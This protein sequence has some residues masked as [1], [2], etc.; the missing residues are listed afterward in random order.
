MQN[1]VINQKAISITRGDIKGK[2]NPDGFQSQE[3][4][5]NFDINQV[6]AKIKEKTWLSVNEIK[7][8]LK[9]IDEKE[10]RKNQESFINIAIETIEKCKKNYIISIAEVKYEKTGENFDDEHFIQEERQSYHENLMESEKSLFNLVDFD[11]NQEEKFVQL[12]DNTPS[13]KLLVKLPKGSEDKFHINTP[14]GKYT[15]DFACDKWKQQ[16]LYDF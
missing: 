7:D 12:A 8:I 2:I 13:V 11:S 5:E 10:M 6:I 3:I 4:I 14:I 1:A 15:P 9:K 16:T